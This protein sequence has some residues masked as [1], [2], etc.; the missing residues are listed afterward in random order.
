[1]QKIK[2]P[3]FYLFLLCCHCV[4]AQQFATVPDSLQKY[5]YLELAD[6]VVTNTTKDPL[7]DKKNYIYAYADLLKSKKENNSK[8]IVYAYLLMV[9][10]IPD[11]SLALKYS[12]SACS[13]SHNKMP[14]LVSRAYFDRG[15]LYYTDNKLRHAL[16]CFI[17]ASRDT[18]NP[19]K[20]LQNRIHYSIGMIKNTQGDYQEALAIYIK[21]EKNARTHKF[22]NYL[23]CLL[24]LSE[25]YNRTNN[26]ALSEQCVNKGIA[27]RTKDENGETYY[28]YFIANR[29]KNEYKRK[30]YN[31]AIANLM[32]SIE[33]FKKSG[34]HSNYAECSFFIGEC[35]REQHLDEK[36]IVYYKKVDSVFVAKKDIYA[37]NIPA[38]E[39][40]IAYYKKKQDYKQVIYYSDQFI[41][42][43]KVLN[44][45]YKYISSK[46]AKTYDIQNVMAGKQAT[47]KMLEKNGKQAIINII[48]LGLA[49]VLLLFGIYLY[50]KQ[51]LT[52]Q[53]SLFD[54][55]I[56]EREEKTVSA[57]APTQLSEPESK[58]NS[59]DKNVVE[60]IATSLISYE[61]EEGFL[62]NQTI[63]D[64]ATALNTN[65][66]YLS[67]VIKEMK[68][69][70]F[71][72]Y[73]NALR[74]D[75][76]IKK[77]ETETKY[78]EYTIEYL[79]QISGY[80]SVVTFARAFKDHTN[81]TPSDFIKQLKNRNVNK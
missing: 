3:L 71:T 5:S 35:Y 42:A 81:L 54:T 78:F 14:N 29:G 44:D 40:L 52:K 46:I 62:I 43:D 47:I 16:D 68:E 30:Q 41:K 13:L 26:I 39:H 8:E 49:F 70:N 6:K 63:D 9:N 60:R 73:N 50:Y 7:I 69:L 65:S 15:Y 1:M 55:F 77:L 20:H 80:N 11:F 67:K 66:T 28:P 12:D 64:L 59:I 10:A 58:K 72:Q 24:G 61:K 34:D 21:C 23:N 27:L 17:I 45:N 32:R 33:A 22:Y 75:Y 48:L 4:V 51:K 57:I 37:I 74:I 25:V 31:K 53:K 18:I 56:K 19:S 2:N 38:Y 76:I 79:S 36:A